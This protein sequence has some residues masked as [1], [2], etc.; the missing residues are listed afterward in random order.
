MNMLL[1]I[2]WN[3][4][5]EFSLF[6]FTLRWYGLLMATGI[7]IAF[8]AVNALY[9]KSNIPDKYMISLLYSIVISALLGARLGEVFFYD[10]GYYMQHPEDILKIWNGGLASHGATI[11]IIIASFFYAKYILKRSFFYVGDRVVVGVAIVAAFV[12][13]GNFTNHE[14][15]GKASNLP[16]AVLFKRNMVNGFPDTIARHPAQIYEALAYFIL[17]VFLYIYFSRNMHK[18]KT[19]TISALF[20]I[21]MFSFRFLVE[22]VKEVQQDFERSLPLDMGQLL[23]IPCIAFGIFALYYSYKKGKVEQYNETEITSE[24]PTT[25]TTQDE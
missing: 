14:I 15:V 12:R 3:F 5:P 21:C 13:L 20:L 11:G 17:F 7:A 19:G 23:S 18:I 10:P 4:D 1:Y 22:F 25:N 2:S 24:S 16:W 8:F 9:Q 6:G